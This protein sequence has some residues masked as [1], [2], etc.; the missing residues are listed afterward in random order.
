M[1]DP[2]DELF[3][4]MLCCAVRYALGR[5]SSAPYTVTQF[6]RPLLPY[7]S[8]NAIYNLQRDVSECGDYGDD[9]DIQTW[10][11]FLADVMTEIRKR[12]I[13]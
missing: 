4:G 12:G 6:I 2:K 1:I 5:T 13:S 9:C 7:L 10:K 11:E 8:D 3:G